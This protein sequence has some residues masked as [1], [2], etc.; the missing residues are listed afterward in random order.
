MNGGWLPVAV[1]AVGSLVVVQTGRGAEKPAETPANRENIKAALKLTQ[2]ATAEYEIRVAGDDKPL[3]LRREPVLRWSNPVQGEVHGNVF[4]WTRD[5][6][7]LVVGSLFKWFSPFTHMSHEFQ[8]LAEKP[9]RATFHGAP[10]WKT[11]KAGLRFVDVPGAAAPAAS[12]AQRLL[13]LKRLA[14]DFT[15]SKKKPRGSETQ[16][17]LLPQPIHRYAAPTQGVLNG[18]LFAFVEGTDPEM[19]LLIE[20]RGKSASSARWQFAATRMVHIEEVRLRHRDKQVWS[21]ESKTMR[22]VLVEHEGVYT[23]FRFKEIP[24]FLKETLAKPKP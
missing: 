16:V 2:A 17:R 19:F 11:S 7:P 22:E 14:K 18:A 12:E 20:A 1:L 8:S 21:E 10:V 3:E 24:D 5:G 15:G 9:L 6:R 4:V 13:Q 23:I